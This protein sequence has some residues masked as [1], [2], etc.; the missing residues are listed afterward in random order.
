MRK[1]DKNEYEGGSIGYYSGREA[2]NPSRGKK[3]GWLGI[4]M[5]L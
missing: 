3:C 4:G 1:S 2:L 5:L